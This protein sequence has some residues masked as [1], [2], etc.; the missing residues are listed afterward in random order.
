MYKSFERVLLNSSLSDSALCDIF[1][2]LNPNVCLYYFKKEL[3]SKQAFVKGIKSVEL[4]GNNITESIVKNLKPE[5][6]ITPTYLDLKLKNVYIHII[7]ESKIFC[8]NCNKYSDFNI[9][10]NKRCSNVCTFHDNPQ[11]SNLYKEYSLEAKTNNDKT[12][13]MSSDNK[14][15]FTKELSDKDKKTQRVALIEARRHQYIQNREDY[16]RNMRKVSNNT[17]TNIKLENAKEQVVIVMCKATTKDSKPCSN[18]AL[19]DSNYCGIV[20][21]RK[22]DPNYIERS[23]NKSTNKTLERLKKL[24]KQT[25][26]SYDI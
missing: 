12:R 19:H 9:S 1:S 8:G 3:I 7:D 22:L 10:I 17:D 24:S 20:S 13:K 6:I 16:K 23:K 2:N 5:L 26:K 11:L 15:D 18:K 21:H 25:V 14:L 4:F